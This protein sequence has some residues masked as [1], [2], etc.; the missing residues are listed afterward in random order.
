MRF[1]F[2]AV[3]LGALGC[4]EAPKI[5]TIPAPVE[6]LRTGP[7]V[8]II[9][10]DTTR[11]DR[12]GFSGHAN[13]STPRLDA[14]AAKGMVF[15]NAI[16]PVPRTTPALASMMTGLAP[17]HHGAR[18]VGEK[19]TAPHT[20]AT[21]LRQKGWA[22]VGISAMPVAGPDQNMD[23]GFD[24]F[25]VDYDAPATA[26]ASAAL[27]KIKDT[28]KACPLFLWTHFS[29]PHFPYAPPAAFKPEENT[30]G[31]DKIAAQ[32]KAGKLARY[33][34][35][36]NRDGRSARVLD[37]CSALYDAEIAFTD[38]GIGRLL[39]G[40]SDL[41]RPNPLIIFTADHGENL[42][43]WGLFFEHG[44]NAHDASTKV[45]L[46]L[47][48]PMISPGQTDMV[49]SLEDIVP[50]VAALTGIDGQYTAGLDGESLLIPPESR[51]AMVV[52]ESGSA[53]HA[54]MGG[55]LVAGRKDK[56]HCIHGERFS[57][58]DHPKMPRRLFD[59][60]ADPDLQRD[61]SAAH[62]RQI[63]RLARAWK[64][65]PAERTRQRFV[66]TKDHVLVAT[67]HIDGSYKTALYDHRSDPLL[68]HD[69]SRDAPEVL[70]ALQARLNRW[71]QEL[72]KAGGPGDARTKTE[73]QALKSLGYI[74]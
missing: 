73:E 74:E 33:R 51:R 63:N 7:D 41:G 42:G 58:C 52:G 48:G 11:A 5:K 1:L 68:A 24:V 18:E 54:R 66:R 15:S 23:R 2:L 14:L 8:V 43:E 22:T 55:F 61:V 27:A 31:C 13:A 17:H 25:E 49:V 6:C 29:D 36:E 44:P 53:L 62:P 28:P 34:Y 60:R 70:R 50:T 65:W 10:I 38:H 57:L 19:M 35:F 32:A 37:Q 3:G 67:P 20:L 9:S 16:A 64:G 40:L 30:R 4:T 39:D 45:P 46:V 12:L 69:I 56:L 21:M 59:R 26:I 71:H 72:D 47:S